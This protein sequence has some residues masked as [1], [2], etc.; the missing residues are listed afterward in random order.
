VPVRIV[1][2]EGEQIEF[3]QKQAS[4]RIPSAASRSMP[5]VA[6]SRLP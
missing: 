5:G 3:V 2:R 4:N 1:A 6:L